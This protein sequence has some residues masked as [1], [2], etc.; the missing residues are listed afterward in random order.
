M[1]CSIHLLP[2]R[3]TDLLSRLPINC[4]ASFQFRCSNYFPP[5]SDSYLSYHLSIV[6]FGPGRTRMILIKTRRS[7]HS[8]RSRKTLRW[9]RSWCMHLRSGCCVLTDGFFL[10]V[11]CFMFEG[12]SQW[13]LPFD[14][15]RLFKMPILRSSCLNIIRTLGVMSLFSCSS[16]MGYPVCFLVYAFLLLLLLSPVSRTPPP[17]M[18]K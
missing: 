9:R 13:R 3:D 5:A 4:T 7:S 15:L 18:E 14:S 11:W 6:I 2:N 17:L 8:A 12:F 16:A 1:K 10:F